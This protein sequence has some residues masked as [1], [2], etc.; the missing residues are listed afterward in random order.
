MTIQHYLVLALAF[1]LVSCGDATLPGIDDDD[2]GIDEP[3]CLPSGSS[4]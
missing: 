1:V 4:H 2:S 3:L